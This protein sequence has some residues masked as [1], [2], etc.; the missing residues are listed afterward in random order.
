MSSLPGSTGCLPA[1]LLSYCLCCCLDSVLGSR[2]M[3]ARRGGRGWGEYQ[4]ERERRREVRERQESSYQPEVE[5]SLQASGRRPSYDLTNK[6]VKL[7]KK[8]KNQTKK[9]KVRQG[10]NKTYIKKK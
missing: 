6:S 8:R 1:D 2:G 7:K 3:G 10:K 4:E 9:I 5:G